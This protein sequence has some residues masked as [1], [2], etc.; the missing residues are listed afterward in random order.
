[1]KSFFYAFF[2]L[3]IIGGVAALSCPD[4]EAHLKALNAKREAQA[5]KETGNA[6]QNFASFVQ[7]KLAG[8]ILEPML[9]VDNY[10][11]CSVGTMSLGS[12]T[13]TLSVGMFNHVFVLD[14]N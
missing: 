14:K 9:S 2:I 6:L 13:E 7:N 5:Q 1:M 11:L 8:V 3:L 10:L 12:E 4:K